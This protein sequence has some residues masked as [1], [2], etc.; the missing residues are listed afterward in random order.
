M[1]ILTSLEETRTIALQCIQQMKNTKRPAL[2]SHGMKTLPQ[3]V[4]GP[5]SMTSEAV[6][7]TLEYI[8]DKLHHTCY[9]LC[10]TEGVRELYKLEP[11]G[12]PE[13]YEHLLRKT[14]KRKP[15][16]RKTLRNKP[17]R[18]M[19]CV[20]KPRKEESATSKEYE[21]FIAECPFALP[22]GVFILNLTDAV[23]LRKD[24]R[25]PWETMT[26]D[27]HR[28]KQSGFLPVLGGS[29]AIGYWDV[30]MPNYD[31]VRVIL[32]YDKIP[33][34]ETNWDAKQPIAVF[35]GG[36]TGCGTT[37]KTN[38]RLRL[39]EMRKEGLDVGLTRLGSPNL[40]L[41]PEQGLS[42]VETN[43]SKVGYLTME[44]Q[45][46]YKYMI[47]V[48]GNVAAYRLLTTMM[49]GSLILK[50]RGLYTLWVDHLLENGVH[51]VSVNEDLSNLDDVL[52]WC[53]SHDREARVIAKRGRD[54]AEKILT[55][56]YVYGSFAK[57]LWTLKKASIDNES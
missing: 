23:I 3:E 42:M 49:S 36:P 44:E 29:G 6:H 53:R 39:A 37:S 13:H 35:R 47:H 52:A 26:R 19:Q 51:Y 48:D 33:N 8:F 32:G 55:Q 12:I 24:G 38:Q 5:W 11:S 31:D 40:K 14:M 17:L 20:V 25:L 41:D 21:R 50:V 9:M 16:L 27:L 34:F 1:R 7:R 45:S 57:L 43:V 54:I 15:A 28:V 10:V 30:P 2:A 4:L 46:R 22:D 56:D 18:V